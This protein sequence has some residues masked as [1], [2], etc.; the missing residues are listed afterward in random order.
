M[1]SKNRSSS[2]RFISSSV[3]ALVFILGFVIQSGATIMKYLEVEDLAQAS[4]HV[5]RG[6]VLGAQVFWTDDHKSIYTATQIRV[7]EGFK[8]ALRKGEIVTVRQPGGEIDGVSLDYDGRPTFQI[9][10][11]VVLF[12]KQLKDGYV[13]T[14]LKQG[15]MRVEGDTVTRDLSGILIVD[16]KGT[17]SLQPVRN[18]RV[19]LPMT[20]LR[21]RLSRVR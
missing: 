14:G 3:L 7:D 10:E 5:F 17:G 2:F 1:T 21:T 18:T 8:G 9:G 15:K 6:E 12:T 19:Q 4:T 20:E 16:K 13:V 11:S